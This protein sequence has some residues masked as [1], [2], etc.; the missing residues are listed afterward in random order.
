MKSL[1]QELHDRSLWQVIGIYLAGSWLV[2]QVV[3]QLTES[4][5][6]PE[7]VPSFALVLLLIGLPIVVATAFL[8]HRAPAPGSAETAEAS[9]LPADGEGHEAPT[10]A[11]AA[12][13]AGKAP[14]G[15]VPHRLFTWRNAILGGVGAAIL[16]GV[17]MAGWSYARNQ[18]IGG[19]GTLVAKGVIEDGERLILAD[20]SG[21]SAM[22]E[23]A[24]MA[25]RVD[26]SQSPTV[27]VA[28]LNFLR[29]VL[30]RME[31]DPET[32]LDEN[33]AR[34]AAIRE[35]VKAI[36]AGDVARAG[37]SY[38]LTARLVAAESGEELISLR[39]TAS[40]SSTVM[41]AVDQ[42][43]RRMRERLGESLG[44]IRASTPLDR[45][46]TT[47]LEALRK[48]SQ[49]LKAI[50]AGDLDLGESLLKEAVELDPEFAMAWR[51]L[52]VQAFDDQRARRAA[53]TRAYEL[54]DLLTDRE[55]YMTIGTYHGYVTLDNDA[56]ITA[57]RTLLEQYPDDA[58]ALNNVALQYEAQ[59]K[60]DLSN[61]YLDRAIEADPYVP[62]AYINLAANLHFLGESDSAHT[63][64]NRLEDVM[65]GTLQVTDWRAR[66]ALADWDYETARELTEELSRT[67]VTEYRRRALDASAAID[68]AEGRLEQAERNWLDARSSPDPIRHADWRAWNELLVRGDEEQAAAVLDRALTEA[69]QVD[70]ADG[71]TERAF[72]YALAGRPDEA[73]RWLEADRRA[74][75]EYSTLPAPLRA[76]E[77]SWFEAALAFGTGRYD[78]A[79]SSLRKAETEMD[80]FYDGLGVRSVSWDLA[81]AFDAAGKADSA[82]AR[83][84]LALEHTDQVINLDDQPRQIPT[85]YLRLARLYD[86]RGDLEEAAGYYGRFVDLWEEA[87]AEF[88][89]KVSA[90]RARLEEIVR[91]RG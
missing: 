34:E 31:V 28:D 10:S 83:Y 5:G 9:A 51:K 37:G 81:R 52:A 11:S 42:L 59:G 53:A 75:N 33:L 70:T 71:A 55:R 50:D 69:V 60:L 4:A 17:V 13:P 40:D 68:L 63:V 23:V 80:S 54:R 66:F 14:G 2:L 1:F 26:L 43:S 41:E 20:F 73:R 45:A 22:A 65:P 79:V 25:F 61:E 88:Q 76:S 74:D 24:T 7:W 91:E 64:L 87:D 21:D 84:E 48:Y 85:T 16:F 6:L 46:T 27:N 36:V 19:A 38:V 72:L 30:Q 58:W 78:E 35:G 56:A 18:G 86:A 57:Y 12:V 89:P 47:S 29:G 49:A 67:D 3:D 44:S 8:Q 32:T 77:D 62:N 15:S 82:I 39:E 90:A